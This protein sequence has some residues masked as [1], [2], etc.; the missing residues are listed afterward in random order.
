LNLELLYG[1]AAEDDSPSPSSP[2][3]QVLAEHVSDIHGIIQE[4]ICHVKQGIIVLFLVNLKQKINYFF[5]YIKKN[6]YIVTKCLKARIE[7]SF[8][9]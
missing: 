5:Q 3:S 6:I 4:C 8:P 7:E 9:K 2:Q 1:Y